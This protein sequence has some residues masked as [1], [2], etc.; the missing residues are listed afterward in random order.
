MS[1]PPAPL[2]RQQV[3]RV[4]Q[5]ALQQ[6]GIASRTLMENAG[7]GAAEL[8]LNFSGP[9]REGNR[10]AV[11]CGRGNNGGDGF[12]IARHLKQ[13]GRE[14]LVLLFADPAELSG[15]AAA[16]YAALQPLE[17]PV[18]S[19]TGDLD[20]EELA[21]EL[22]G[23]VWVVDALLGTGAT[24]L[25]RPPYPAAIRAINT[26]AN[27]AVRVLAVDLPSGLDADAGE[28][29]RTAAGQYGPCVRAD[30]TATFVARKV[31][32]DRPTSRE[33]TGQVVVVDIGVPAEAV[34]AARN[35]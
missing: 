26:A 13:A 31:G 12:V 7:R 21:G 18:R 15:D 10:V 29:T 19:R 8:L 1:M 32:F 14:V 17:I 6:Y 34:E 22:A 16:M 3:R 2:T 27:A 4:D 23:A 35:E 24:G 11:L 33:F 9:L 30:L 5:I 25:A 20:A 28:P